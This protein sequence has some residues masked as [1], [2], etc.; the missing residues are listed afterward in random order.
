MHT[1]TKAFTVP[2]LFVLLLITACGNDAPVIPT[3]VPSTPAP[4]N[5]APTAQPTSPSSEVVSTVATAIPAPPPTR[6]RHSPSPTPAQKDVPEG[7]DHDLANGSIDPGLTAE[8]SEDPPSQAQT[9]ETTP[10]NIRGGCQIPDATPPLEIQA[11]NL[12]A[13]LPKSEYDCLPEQFK[14]GTAWLNLEDPPSDPQLANAALSCISDENI[15]RLFLVSHLQLEADLSEASIE[16]LAHSPA[17]GLIRRMVEDAAALQNIADHERIEDQQFGALY[18]S[19]MGI[20]ASV[21][22]CLPPEELEEMGILPEEQQLFACIFKDPDTIG[23]I[24]D[25]L[26][27]Q[28]TEVLATIEDTAETCA[29]QIVR[30]VHDPQDP[31]LEAPPQQA[32]P[33]P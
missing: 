8:P 21:L 4:E 27:Q 22:Q 32:T 13:Q 6:G 11:K 25:A 18:Y 16:C 9:T 2:M 5:Q 19:L 31:T 30:T 12:L 14:D 23:I 1:A 3:V 29:S 33:E 7:E 28:D 20:A 24:L 10:C 17:G 26:L 15:N